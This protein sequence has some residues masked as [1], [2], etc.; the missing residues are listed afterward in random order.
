M[1]EKGDPCKYM[2]RQTDRQ[3]ADRQQADRETDQQLHSVSVLL[4]QLLFWFGPLNTSPPSI[5][6]SLSLSFSL[7]MIDRKNDWQEGRRNERINLSRNWEMITLSSCLSIH[8]SV[9]PL[10]LPERPTLRV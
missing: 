3:Q 2:D 1:D 6:P 10:S 8:Q 7:Q 5:H 4:A 9:K